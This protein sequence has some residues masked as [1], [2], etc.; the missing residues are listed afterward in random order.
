[1]HRKHNIWPV[2]TCKTEDHTNKYFIAN[3][4][5]QGSTSVSL[6]SAPYPVGIDIN[7]GV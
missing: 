2:G 4:T 1:M 7:Y 3:D 5:N 6:G